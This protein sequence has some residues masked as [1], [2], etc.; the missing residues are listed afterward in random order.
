[1]ESKIPDESLLFPQSLVINL[2]KDDYGGY[3]LTADDLTA[4]AIEGITEIRFNEPYDEFSLICNGL[5]FV[6]DRNREQFVAVTSAYEPHTGDGTLVF[7]H[8]CIWANYY[9]GEHSVEKL[10]HFDYCGSSRENNYVMVQGVEGLSH[11]E[12]WVSSGEAYRTINDNPEEYRDF[13]DAWGPAPT[14]DNFGNSYYHE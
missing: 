9:T 4:E 6:Y 12:Y 11:F 7:L 8:A 1:M 13:A 10:S 5:R 3:E 2:T 14:E